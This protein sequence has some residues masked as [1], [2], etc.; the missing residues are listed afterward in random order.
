MQIRLLTGATPAEYGIPAHPPCPATP[1]PFHTVPFRSVPFRS[2]QI[3]SAAPGIRIVC[4]KVPE[5]SPD[6]GKRATARKPVLLQLQLYLHLRK[7]GKKETRK[8]PGDDSK[9][10]A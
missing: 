10:C 7:P 9:E 4:R 1:I 2:P 5:L 8:T 6:A 3:R